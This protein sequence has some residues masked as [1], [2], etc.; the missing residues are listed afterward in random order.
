MSDPNVDA[1]LQA[2]DQAA[3]RHPLYDRAMEDLDK[4]YRASLPL[5]FLAGPPLVGKS[6]LARAFVDKANGSSAN[7]VPVLY[8]AA[9][10][11]C[12]STFYVDRF[13][14]KRLFYP[15][16]NDIG[17]FVWVCRC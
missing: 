11:Q 5:G 9:T 7:E 12:G 6:R 13:L 4:F 10:G 8:A 3:V 16:L 17:R 14:S 15:L 1:I 2:V